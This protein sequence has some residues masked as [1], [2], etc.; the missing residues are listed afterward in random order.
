MAD[1]TFIYKSTKVRKPKEPHPYSRV[2]A[3]AKH[4][5]IYVSYVSLDELKVIPNDTI[6]GDI[7]VLQRSK[8][9]ESDKLLTINRELSWYHDTY[10]LLFGKELDAD[11]ALDKNVFSLPDTKGSTL[12]TIINGLLLILTH[13][14][15]V[16]SVGG[17]RVER[18]IRSIEFPPEYYQSGVT[19]LS[20][21]ASVLRHKNISD[22]IKVS[23]EQNGLV[24]RLIIESPSGQR[25]LIERTLDAYALVITGK[26]SID[27]LTTDPFEVMELKSQLRIAYI[28]LQNQRDLLDLSKS[29]VAQLRTGLA[30]T[31][32]ALMASERR[33]EAETNRFMS[34]LEGL[35]AN[36][37]D[38]SSGFRKLSEQA[39][40]L[41]NSTLANALKSLHGLFER[42]LR[43]D[44][45]EDFIEKMEAIR[46]ED[47]GV[48]SPVCDILIKG[49]ISGAAGN[50]LYSWL[51]FIIGS[52]PK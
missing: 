6:R 8:D 15:E 7:V 37:S 51:Q 16:S 21:F 1:I 28:Q 4:N 40:A 12:V 2:F 38:L 19:I 35:I 32:E 44:D 14:L 50:Y 48:F 47:S 17:G 27:K 33:A 30:E 36:N 10:T 34:L 9:G 29:E 45:R 23:I 25:E 5:V 24:V 46:Q 13:G 39:I 49:A 20:Y 3:N 42:G 22:N 52:L 26:F 11:I 41:Q 18:I 31:R 43:E